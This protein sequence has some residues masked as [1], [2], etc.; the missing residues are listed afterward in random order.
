MTEE[1]QYAVNHARQHGIY[2]RKMLPIFYRAIKAQVMPVLNEL[3][4]NKP[5][6]DSDIDRIVSIN[7]MLK[8]F[9]ISYGIVGVESAK[10]DY[11]RLNRSE[12]KKA[13]GVIITFLTERWAR[14]MRG[15]ALNELADLVTKITD[16]TKEQIRLALAEAYEQ[17]LPYYKQAQLIRKYTLG[18]IGEKRAMV[19]SRTEA[20]RATNVGKKIASDDWAKENGISTMY[21]KWITRLDGHE[22]KSHRL[23][24]SVKPIPTENKFSVLNDKGGFDLMDKPGDPSASASN[25]I[26]CR[27]TAFYISERKA[28]RDYGV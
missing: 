7:P 2:E 1:Q 26:H 10:K 24:N 8:A 11:N 15:F 3:V 13:D 17:G 5:V 27:C 9:E 12:P 16:T 18:E 6:T 23:M 4:N 21:K 14:F 28:R 19:I 20:T 22:R 25:T